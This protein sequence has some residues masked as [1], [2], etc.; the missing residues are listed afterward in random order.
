MKDA[1]KELRQKILVCS[2]PS[3]L[4]SLVLDCKASGTSRWVTRDQRGG[5][6]DGQSL[7]SITPRGFLPGTKGQFSLMV[8]Q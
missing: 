4:M 3:T 8:L 5:G 1:A 6:G 2:D 7:V